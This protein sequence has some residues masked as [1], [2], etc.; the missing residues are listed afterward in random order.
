[1]VPTTSRRRYLATVGSAMVATAG[2]CVH[3]SAFG[4]TLAEGFESELAGWDRD[5]HLGADADGVFQ[6]DIERTREV[7]KSGEWSLAIFT[8]GR[9]DDG[10][11]WIVRSIEVAGIAP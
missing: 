4:Y 7:V 9:F 8:E 11:A 10:T 2:G 5:S 6:W 1:M 3:D